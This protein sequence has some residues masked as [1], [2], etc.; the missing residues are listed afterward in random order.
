MARSNC[1]PASSGEAGRQFVSSVWFGAFMSVSQPQSVPTHNLNERFTNREIAQNGSKREL[2][3]AS[4]PTRSPVK[5]KG[6]PTEEGGS[7]K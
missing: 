1:G 4:Q 7:D 5:V 6:P 3:K 2:Q